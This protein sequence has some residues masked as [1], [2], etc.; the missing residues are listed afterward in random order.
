MKRVLAEGTHRGLSEQFGPLALG[1]LVSKVESKQELPSKVMRWKHSAGASAE[2]MTRP[3]DKAINTSA[4]VRRQ[5]SGYLVHYDFTEQRLTVRPSESAMDNVAPVWNTKPATNSFRARITLLPKLLKEILSNPFRDFTLVKQ[6]DEVLVIEKGV[7]LSGK[8]LSGAD[9]R[10]AN[11]EKA[12]LE[13]ALLIN[14]DFEE[15]NL[16]GAKLKNAVLR[17]A[18]LRRADMQGTTL[19]GSDL[20]GADLWGANID[21]A[22]LSRNTLENKHSSYGGTHS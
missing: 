4:I 20:R 22:V 19:D 9:L 13:G 12:N 21:P 3:L 14:T 1:N 17:N 5:S 2:F 18:N 10:R 11:L 7:D 8:N 15:A 16:Q 6:G